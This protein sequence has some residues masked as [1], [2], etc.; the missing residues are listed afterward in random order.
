[1]I[2]T[3]HSQHHFGKAGTLQTLRKCFYLP[4]MSKDVE[5]FCRN[6]LVCHRAKPTN[7]GKQPI[8]EMKG[9]QG[10]PGYTEGIGVG[11]LP[12]SE[13]G[14]R[15]FLLMV[16]LFIRHIEVMP[17]RNQ[18]AKTLWRHLSKGECTE[19]TESPAISSAIRDTT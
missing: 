6:C 16:D 18:H 14:Y 15:H 9:N 13:D 3:V 2:E 17:L 5:L 12:W 4:K 19:D 1:M 8:R 11:T 10:I 7:S